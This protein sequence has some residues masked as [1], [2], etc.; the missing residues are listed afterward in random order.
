MGEDHKKSEEERF[1]EGLRQIL[2]GA[3]SGGR[4][5]AGKP[6]RPPASPEA[7]APEAAFKPEPESK[8]LLFLF[9]MMRPVALAAL[10]LLMAKFVLRII[11]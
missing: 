3:P 2:D 6:P 5:T 9:K 10:L 4:V 1:E 11:S 8:T 7:K